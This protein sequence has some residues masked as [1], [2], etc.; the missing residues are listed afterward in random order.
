MNRGRSYES[1]LL[2]YKRPVGWE[3]RRL[4]YHRRHGGHRGDIFFP[5]TGDGIQGKDAS[6]EYE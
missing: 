2:W 5:W 4:V 1:A 6:W 3:A